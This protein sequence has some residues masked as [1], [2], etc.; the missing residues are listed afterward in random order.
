MQDD[1]I[2]IG[3]RTEAEKKFS[4]A[5]GNNANAGGNYSTAIGNYAEADGLNSIAIGSRLD[6]SED[7]NVVALGAHSIAI[8]TYARATSDGQIVLCADP[9]GLNAPG[10]SDPGFFVKPIRG[11]SSAS[12]DALYYN[13]TT[14]EIT[15]DGDRRLQTDLEA[16]IA[17][18]EARNADLEARLEARLELLEKALAL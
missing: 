6:E 16:R 8:G 14:G 3:S 5:L 1:A 15:Y 7:L 18:L 13:P 4:I 11:A 12:G 10:A 17:D 2:A 9:D